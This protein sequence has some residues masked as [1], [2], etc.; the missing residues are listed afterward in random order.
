MHKPL[1]LLGNSE[2]IT[3]SDENSYVMEHTTFKAA[4]FIDKLREEAYGEDDIKDQWFGEG[5]ECE[6]LQ[7]G[8][9]WRKG[10]IKV[11]LV[12]VPDEPINSSDEWRQDLMS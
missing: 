10:K 1:H 9:Q 7:P 6:M 12:F 11:C 4:E 2:V 3:V 5:A 8:Q